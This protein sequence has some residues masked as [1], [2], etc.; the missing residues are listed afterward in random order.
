MNKGFLG[1]LGV[2]AVVALVAVI[3]FGWGTGQYNGLVK[4]QEQVNAAWSQVEN[5]YQRRFDLIPN[6][7]ETVKGAADFERETYTA[8]TEARSK[9]GQI[10]MSADLLNDPE[11][12]KRF[13]AAQGQLTSALS[14]LMVVAENYPQLKAN[15]N[16]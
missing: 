8:V 14:R 15:Q 1:C 3:A 13:E 9:V 10:K 16:F 2:L 4:S 11:A 5:V 7:V 6:L 12:F